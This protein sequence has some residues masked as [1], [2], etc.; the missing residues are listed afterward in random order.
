MILDQD[1]EVKVTGYNIRFYM[2]KFPFVKIG[3]TLSLNQIKDI[4]SR[5]TMKV[6]CECSFKKCKKRFTKCRRDISTENTFCSHK[7]RG[8]FL[9]EGNLIK[10]REYV[11]EEFVDR[12][13][14]GKSIKY[15]DIKKENLKLF[16]A[17]EKYYPV[18]E[19]LR[20]LKISEEDAVEKFNLTRNFN[21]KTLS[22]KEIFE[23]LEYLKSIKRLNT[24]AM[25]TEFDDL[26]L[27][28]S[29]KKIFGSVEKCFEEL[30]YERDYF[31]LE[32]NIQ[33]G[34][35]F[36][37]LFKNILKD[38]DISHEY[39]KEMENGTIPDFYLPES[40]TIIDTKLSSWTPSI[41]TDIEKYSPY[42]DNLCFVYLREGNYK[43]SREKVKCVSVYSYI[44]KMNDNK[45]EY[46]KN[47][48][49]KILSNH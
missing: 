41:E 28:I 4:P 20:D 19:L 12:I 5:S 43:L 26:R 33:M 42:C 38:L 16:N 18:N 15:K 9:K 45:K 8:D 27:E 39:Q 10:H 47:E 35:R 40:S 21:K 13:R 36:E 17:I 3:D 25:R 22:K 1:I 2:N 23:R 29:I 48:I 30:G 34:L 11:K 7:C 14:A 44:D 24:S 37:H 49:N 31:H 46:Y 32:K 6:E